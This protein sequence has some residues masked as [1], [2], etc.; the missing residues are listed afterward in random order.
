MF[1][2]IFLNFQ[3]S[4][5]IQFCSVVKQLFLLK[6]M[7]NDTWHPSGSSSTIPDLNSGSQ[8]LMLG[9]WLLDE[10][11]FENLFI[12]DSFNGEGSLLLDSS[13]R[14]C[15]A[16]ETTLEYSSSSDMSSGIKE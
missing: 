10:E 13:P 12:K 4:I 3:D 6:K 7:C 11:N 5:S 9:F 8:L 15:L 16:S 14:R 1:R 2:A